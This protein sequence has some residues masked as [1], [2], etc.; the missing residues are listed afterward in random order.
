M[1]LDE[2]EVGDAG[3]RAVGHRDPVSD[4][5]GRVGRALPERGRATR[6]EERRA[7][8]DR[9][10]VGRNADAPPTCRPD[11]ARLALANRDPRMGEDALGERVRD[12]APRSRAARVDHARA[13]M[14]ALETE[15]RVELDA[16]V[17]E[18]GDTR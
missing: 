7:G 14:P 2:L 6:R 9:A 15:A 3:S 18:I 10:A 11:P 17:G 1:E 12:L 16:Q 13:R 4:G 5:A 8:L